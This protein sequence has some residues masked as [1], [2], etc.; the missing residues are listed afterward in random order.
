[1]ANYF[2]RENSY[3]PNH[4]HQMEHEYPLVIMIAHTYTPLPLVEGGSLRWVVNCLDLS[5]RSMNRYKFT[6]SLISQKLNKAEKEVSK[7]LDGVRCVVIYYD[8]WMSKTT[9][10]FFQ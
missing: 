9:Q 3:G 5:I 2:G 4:P 10:E 6:R 8:L 1:M 7:F